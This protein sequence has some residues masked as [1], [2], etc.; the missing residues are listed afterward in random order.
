MFRNR[1]PLPFRGLGS[2]V[3]QRVHLVS[4]RASRNRSSTQVNGTISKSLECGNYRVMGKVLSKYKS[5]VEGIVL[6]SYRYTN[7]AFPFPVDP[8]H[9]PYDINETG[10]Y[11]RSFKVPKNFR[12]HQLRL[13]FEGVDSAFHV[14]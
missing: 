4:Q 7:T 10:C 9:V 3:W 5:H 13:R 2:S 6:M 1:R 14:W 12:K 8:G 11:V